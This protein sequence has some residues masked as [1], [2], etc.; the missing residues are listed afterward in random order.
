MHD[1]AT[2]GDRQQR[3]EDIDECVDESPLEAVLYGGCRGRR[4]GAWGVRLGQGL[5]D[6]LGRGLPRLPTSASEAEPATH[7]TRLAGRRLARRVG[8]AQAA[9]HGEALGPHHRWHDAR[10]AATAA[11]CRCRATSRATDGSAHRNCHGS[12]HGHAHRDGNGSR[13]RR[14]SVGDQSSDRFCGGIAQV[15]KVGDVEPAARDQGRRSG[16]RRRRRRRVCGRP[17]IWLPDR[18]S[19]MGHV[20][21]CGRQPK[22]CGERGGKGGR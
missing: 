14:G 6:L 3:H 12:S 1:G 22:S 2:E 19:G 18:H 21:R 11:A 10:H 20:E 8:V 5:G 15:G 4:R 17:G 7:P 9:V 16:W 13:G